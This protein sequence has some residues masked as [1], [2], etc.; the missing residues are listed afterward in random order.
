[1]LWA[2]FNLPG[3][4]EGGSLFT[5]MRKPRSTTAIRLI[6]TLVLA[7]VLTAP[8]VEAQTYRVIYAFTG[9]A[10]GANP[11]G[12]TMDSAGNLYGVA[13]QGGNDFIQAC[14]FGQT[15]GCG[16]VFKLTPTGGSWQFNVLYAFTGAPDGSIPSSSPT[17]GPDGN[18][19]GTT[20]W[21]GMGTCV[22]ARG[23]GT[24]YEVALADCRSG[25]CTPSENILYR[26]SGGSDGAKPDNADVI[27]DAAGNLYGTAREGGNTQHN[28]GY[29]V[30]YELMPS[31]GWTEKVLYTFNG[32]A[33]GAHPQAGVTMDDVGKLYGTT[34]RGGHDSFLCT[35]FEA[36]GCGVVFQLARL[37]DGWTENVLYTFQGGIDGGQPNAGLILDSQGNLYG[38]TLLSFSSVIG[39]GTLFQLT[40]HGQGWSFQL[41]PLRGSG[42]GPYAKLVMDEQGRLY[43][44][45]YGIPGSVFQL[46][47]SGS[48]WTCRLLHQFNGADG[49]GPYALVLAASA[50]SME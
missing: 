47:P 33:D 8:A 21:G 29:G 26:F 11:V 20:Y 35:L 9:G 4:R 19:Y 7:A 44:G 6:E 2:G 32:G 36:P 3:H 37:G 48:G 13:A 14:T 45:T 22:P 50:S 28:A 43:G 24:V 34:V 42:Y 40:P 16:T 18:L 49:G 17:L 31:G 25:T 46:T 41:L 12:L 15:N 23:C 39:G 10:D 5:A 27:F 38:S 30:V 1:M